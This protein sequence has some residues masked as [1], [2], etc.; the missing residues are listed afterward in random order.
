MTHYQKL[1]TMFFRTISCSFFVLALTVGLLC[2]TA[3]F[4]DVQF[5][6]ILLFLI[7]YSLPLA[8]FGIVFWLLSKTLAK[9]VSK[10]LD[11]SNEK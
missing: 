2:F 4:F 5:G 9:F 6:D 8:I 7:F 11:K 10:D 3:P 1:A